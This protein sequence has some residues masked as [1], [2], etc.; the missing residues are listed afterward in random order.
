LLLRCSTTAQETLL[1]KEFVYRSSRN[2]AK[3]SFF[4]RT[5]VT[6]RDS[7]KS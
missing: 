1:N 4:S 7:Q 5:I 2:Q 6:K 3:R